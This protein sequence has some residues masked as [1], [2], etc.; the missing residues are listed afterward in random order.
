MPHIVRLAVIKANLSDLLFPIF[1][2]III[3]HYS[4]VLDNVKV[5]FPNICWSPGRK[6]LE[7]QGLLFKRP[8][9]PSMW[10]KCQTHPNLLFS[11]SQWVWLWLAGFHC[12]IT[13]SNLHSAAV[14]HGS[15][16]F[17]NYKAETFIHLVMYNKIVMQ[18]FISQKGSCTMNHE[19]A[20][21]RWQLLNFLLPLTA[22]TLLQ[23]FF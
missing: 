2:L 1:S 14:N 18:C 23:V 17:L 19:L 15:A 9:H 3:N 11:P 6:A 12:H 22:S 10:S 5:I 8:G 20:I 4:Q 16:S 21:F 13:L 7:V